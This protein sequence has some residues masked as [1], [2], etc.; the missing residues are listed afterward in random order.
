MTKTN[1]IFKFVQRTLWFY[2]A[3]AVVVVGI[4]IMITR[5]HT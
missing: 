1:I 2:V 5:V 4:F 3:E